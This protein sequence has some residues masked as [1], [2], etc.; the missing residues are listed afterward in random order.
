MARSTA[1]PLT[2]KAGGGGGGGGGGG[3][4]RAGGGGGG[5]GG[6]RRRDRGAVVRRRRPADG[7]GGGEADV[8]GDGLE[9]VEGK[10]PPPLVPIAPSV[11]Q[12]GLSAKRSPFRSK[13]WIACVLTLDGRD[14]FTKVLQYASRLLCWKFAGLAAAAAA[15]AGASTEPGASDGGGLGGGFGG[16]AALASSSSPLLLV[17][18]LS[19]DPAVRTRLYLALSKRFEALYKTLVTSRKAFRLGRSLIEWDKLRGMGWGEYLG[20]LLAHPLAEGL[21]D[22]QGEGRG[23]RGGG[24]GEKST[25]GRGDAGLI[26]RDTH[27]IPEGREGSERDEDNGDEDDD[28]GDGEASW[29]E[30]EDEEEKKSDSRAAS[31]VAS[32]PGR[33]ALP[34]RISSNVGWGPA[35]TATS[36]REGPSEGDAKA[37]GREFAPPARTVSRLGRRMYRPFPSRSSS[38]GSYTQLRETTIDDDD[39]GKALVPKPPETPA[40]KLVGGTAKL[41]GLMGFWAFDNA[42]FLTGCGFLDPIALHEGKAMKAV[43]GRAQRKKRASEYAAKCY[44]LAVLGGFY[45]N[46]RSVWE[47]RAV[48]QLARKRLERHSDPNRRD[49][50]RGDEDGIDRKALEED[51]S[52]LEKVQRKHFALALALTKSCCDFLVFSNNPGVDLHLKY[53]GKKNHEGLHC[54]GGLVSAGTVLYNNFPNA[55]G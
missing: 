5:G 32:R 43:D 19:S 49:Y 40:W 46:F 8:D 52:D 35:T 50:F 21:A 41:V 36:S 24:K 45:V 28:D 17:A 18:L 29:D 15:A 51:R 9:G 23:G 1:A 37:Q 3:D 14:K 31:R 4:G 47:H 6:A 38:M 20:Y 11:I 25:K 13:H 16:T 7:D 48:L 44:F 2:F 39:A 53:R 33:P 27:P 34:S 55:G 42:A 22:A 10:A 26:R 12:S 54:L 30:D